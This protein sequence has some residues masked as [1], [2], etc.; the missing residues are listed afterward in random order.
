[1]HLFRHKHKGKKRYK[2]TKGH[3]GKKAKRQ[4]AQRQKGRKAGGQ[5][6]P[7]RAL[8]MRFIVTGGG[9]GGHIYPALAIAKGLREKY[10]QAEILYIGKDGGLEA[11]L[12]PAEGFTF[13]PVRVRGLQRRL[14]LTNLVALW[15]AGTAF[16]HARRMI[17]DFQP[18]AV[19]GTG[20]YV[21]GPVIL[22]AVFLKV[23]ALVHEQNALPGVTT[24]LLARLVKLT[25]LTFA[26]SGQHLPRQ[27]RFKVTGLPVRPEFSPGRREEARKALG[28]PPEG[29]F[30]LSFGGSQGARTLNRAM[31]EV[32]TRFRDRLDVR[33][34]HVTGPAQYEE[35][36]KGFPL[37]E[38]GNTTIK[39]YLY[40]MPL[41]L[42]AADLVICRAGAATLAELT[43]TGTPAILA[44]YP[45]AA[46]NHQEYNARALAEE[47]AAIVIQDAEL[48]GEVLANQIDKLLAEPGRLAAMAEASRRLGRPRA[49]ADI[50]QCV[51]ELLEEQGTKAQRPKGAKGLKGKSI[52]VSRGQ[53]REGK[54][55]KGTKA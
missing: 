36:C 23:P 9:T 18:S 10:P 43:L 53:G 8:K 54:K 5:T 55:H 4:E 13:R 1:M 21:C 11:D 37:P 32:I 50:L 33:F 45:Y 30:I 25:A 20:G 15:Q 38:N 44:P 48:T 34:L 26:G 41:A 39:P 7:N 52:R 22:A 46:G 40:E 47:G 51:E 2:G 35:F 31:Q 28:L 19:I 49:L 6:L 3:K 27:A 42:S 12:V 24:R 17:S 16:F 29:F 14:S